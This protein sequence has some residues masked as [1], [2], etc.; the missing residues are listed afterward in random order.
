MQS[1]Q[2]LECGLGVFMRLIKRCL[3]CCLLLC[4]FN[5]TSLEAKQPY[6]VDVTV[7][8]FSA[9]V[10]A[11]NLTDL[12]RDLSTDSLAKDLPTYTTTSAVSFDI[13]LR[14][15]ET[16]ASFAENSTE[17]VVTFPN[18][19]ST[20]T[21]DGGTRDN[22]VTL[23][24][25]FLQD[26]GAKNKLL[27]AYARFSPIDPIAGNPTSLLSLMA[28]ADYLLGR[29]SPYAGCCCDW[30]TQPVRHQFQL[31]TSAA[32]TFN[33]EGFDSTVVT[34]PLRYSYS[35]CL[36]WALILDA[37][38]TYIRNGGASSVVSSL[39]LGLRVPITDF[40]ALTATT[41]FG[42]GGSVDLCTA[43]AFFSPG[44]SSQLDYGFW[45]LVFSMTNYVGYFS[46]TNMWLGGINLNYH[47][48]DYVFKNGITITACE[49][50]ELCG[51]PLGFNISFVDTDFQR[52]RLYISHYDEVGFQIFTNGINPCLDYDCAILGFSYMFGP[53]NYHGYNFNLIYQF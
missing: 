53:K 9:H 31:G 50:F 40:W 13:D 38:I 34:L 19:D 26:A 49:G 15:L 24:K 7:D 43:G 25:E 4:G 44:I 37:P 45:G 35:P 6:Q 22:S 27:R 2:S 14:G 1:L 21:F 20:V 39:A 29:L 23:F 46:S 36:D 33:R 16:I 10:S 17:L 51:Y 11:P 32:R 48:H 47:L 3:G 28:N 12:R 5:S 18:I 42:S 52:E 8:A 41:R 30:I